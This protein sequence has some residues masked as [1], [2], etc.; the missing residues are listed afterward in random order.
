MTRLQTCPLCSSSESVAH[1]S[2]TDLLVDLGIGD[3]PHLLASIL[4]CSSCGFVY[5]EPLATEALEILYERMSQESDYYAPSR[6]E[7][8]FFG[9]HVEA[10]ARVLDWGCG[11]G[12]FSETVAAAGGE[13]L[14]VD[15]A[16]PAIARGRNLGRNLLTTE[17]F[18]GHKGVFDLVVL[19]QVLEHLT[20]PLGTVRGLISLISERGKIAIAV[21]NPD[22]SVMWAAGVALEFPPHHLTRWHE[23]HL[24]SM[25]R[26]LGLNTVAYKAHQLSAEHAGPW[27]E[28]SLRRAL[29]RNNLVYR[30]RGPFQ[31]VTVRVARSL[32]NWTLANRFGLY[33][34]IV[35]QRP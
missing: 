31:R 13:Y 20:D 1:R 33:H 23:S 28:G 25:G 5:S 17:E 3:A 8:S 27:I 34:S 7:F 21:P 9:G 6:P 30:R 4:V 12:N 10:G 18:D 35:F 32:P 16:G 19:N 26:Q 24:R 2:G 29:R 11:S 14:G 22:S 15:F